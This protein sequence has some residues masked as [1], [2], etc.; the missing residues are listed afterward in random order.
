MMGLAWDSLTN[1]TKSLPGILKQSKHSENSLRGSYYSFLL[2]VIVDHL[3]LRLGKV[4]PEEP[5]GKCFLEN[6]FSREK[7]KDE[8]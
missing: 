7:G 5:R 8:L 1:Q 2:L 3:E 6:G 4:F